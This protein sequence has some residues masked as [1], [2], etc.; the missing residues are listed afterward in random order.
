MVRFSGTLREAG[1]EPSNGETTVL[2]SLYAQPS[3]GDAVWSESHTVTVRDGRYT[4]LLGS[5]NPDGLPTDLFSSEQAR[6][7]AVTVQGQSEGARSLL[8]S[9]PFAMKAVEAERLSGK[10]VTDF[11]SNEQLQA[12]VEAAVRKAVQQQTAPT[13]VAAAA[14]GK[15]TRAS[16]STCAGCITQGPTNFSGNNVQEI[17]LVT[18]AGTG[19]AINALAPNNAITGRATA[20]T[21]LTYGLLG[22]SDSDNGRGLRGEALSTSG[23]FGTVGVQA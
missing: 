8:V 14:K 13:A 9:V 10:P 15:G 17:L 5:S 22:L 11:V 6:W 2:V 20:A 1:G 18:Q 16:E 3:G 7:M 19:Y 23:A 12:V 4:I 21:G